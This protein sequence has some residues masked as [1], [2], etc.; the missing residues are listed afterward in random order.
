MPGL[1][2]PPAVNAA[3]TLSLD[4]RERA[5]ALLVSQQVQPQA[6]VHEHIIM[7]TFI[8]DG[9]AAYAVLTT[10]LAEADSDL[11]VPPSWTDPLPG[12]GSA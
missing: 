7:A 3:D 5:A 1:F 12:E 8:C 6:N 4:Q 10:R 11:V 2:N 9:V